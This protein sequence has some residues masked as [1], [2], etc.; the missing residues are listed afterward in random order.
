MTYTGFRIFK[1]TSCEIDRL[2]SFSD[3]LKSYI[4]K[5]R[6]LERRQ[7]SANEKMVSRFDFT[8]FQRFAGRFRQFSKYNVTRTD[9][10]IILICLCNVDPITPQFYVAKAGFTGVYIIF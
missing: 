9:Y 7:C 6:N 5:T 8:A 10:C 4:Y 3:W 2:K 1:P